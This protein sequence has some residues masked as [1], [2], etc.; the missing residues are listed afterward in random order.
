MSSSLGV[1]GG[2]F[3]PVHNG[4]LAIASLAKEYFHLD[5]ILLI[6]SGIPPHKISTVKASSSDRLK[7]LRLAIDGRNG[8]EICTEEIN[9][10]GYSYTFD[11]LKAL[12]EQHENPQIYFIIGSDN[13]REISTWYKY[14]EVI[15]IVTL[16]VAHRPGYSCKIPEELKAARILKFPSPEW[17][18]SSTMVRTYFQR[19]YSCRHLLPD[20][21]ID[22]I[23]SKG[24]YRKEDR[25]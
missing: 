24:L 22:Y 7:M 15:E 20:P 3:D 5:K 12:K 18:I 2:I 9:R 13:L 21:V 16:C 4:H 8:F 6:P 17:A 25:S 23:L 14:K 19:G 10:K 1:L 11:T